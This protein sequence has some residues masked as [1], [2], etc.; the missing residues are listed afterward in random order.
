M[1]LHDLKQIIQ[2]NSV[3]ELQ[4]LK[5]LLSRMALF[6]SLSELTEDEPLLIE[7]VGLNSD[8]LLVF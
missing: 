7:R 8:L 5:D 1:L 3:V 4:Y 2:R 6:K